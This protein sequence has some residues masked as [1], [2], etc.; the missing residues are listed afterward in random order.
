MARKRKNET[1]PLPDLVVAPS[2]REFARGV[3]LVTA[4]ERDGELTFE[5]G[6]GDARPVHVAL[7]DGVRLARGRGGALFVFRHGYLSGV[8]LKDALTLRWCWLPAPDPPP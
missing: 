3:A 7:A 8:T 2:T 4:Y 5:A 1:P 6:E